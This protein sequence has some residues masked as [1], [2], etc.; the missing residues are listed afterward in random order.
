MGKFPHRVVKKKLKPMKLQ[1]RLRDG[2]SLEELEEKYFVVA[3]PHPLYPNLLHFKYKSIIADFSHAITRE[4]RAVILDRDNNWECVSRTFD[5]FF[6][7]GEKYAAHINW[8]NAKVQEK[9]DGSLAYL[10]E[11]QG[12]WLVGTSGTPNA[13]GEVGD[14]GL[15]FAELYWR[16][17]RELSLGLPPSG[18]GCTFICELM[19]PINRVVVKH[20]TPRIVLLAVRRASTGEYQNAG[21]F[22][23]VD[24]NQPEHVREFS[25][26]GFDAIHESFKTLDPL[27]QE[28]YV[29]VDEKQNRVKVKHPGYVALHHAIF[30]LT[31]KAIMRVVMQGE[32]VE[33]LAHFP[34][35]KA[36]FLRYQT[37]FEA[38]CNKIDTTYAQIK[39]IDLQKEFAQ[40]AMQYEYFGIMFLMRRNM[41]A[42]AKECL[43]LQ[44][45]EV[46]MKLSGVRDLV[47][48]DVDADS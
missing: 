28:G 40:K 4:S 5:K 39:D 33:V 32:T 30:S 25:L 23:W 1:E 13:S 8:G 3:K 20:E 36:E 22:L 37:A 21:N 35:F 15:T 9:N 26:H 45:V 34:E 10:Y 38:V 48:V 46:V 31:A 12:K 19:T 29:V 2:L 17:H 44:R 27:T 43:A 42:T 24:G 7:Y 11:Y 41:I 16:T 47:G 18:T 14:H 6:N